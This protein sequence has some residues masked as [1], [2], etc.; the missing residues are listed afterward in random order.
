LEEKKTKI[1]NKQQRDETMMAMKTMLNIEGEKVRVIINTGVA[2][3]VITNKL[4]KELNTNT[5]RK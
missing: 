5:E 1:E 3:S 2:T 4:R